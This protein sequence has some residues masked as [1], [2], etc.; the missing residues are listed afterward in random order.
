MLEAHRKRLERSNNT[1]F[2]LIK[3]ARANLKKT[4]RELTQNHQL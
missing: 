4:K 3:L 1:K 2:S